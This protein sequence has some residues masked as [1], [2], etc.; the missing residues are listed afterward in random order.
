MRVPNELTLRDAWMIWKNESGS[1][2]PYQ[3]QHPN[4]RAISNNKDT[5]STYEEACE[6]RTNG[7]GIGIALGTKVDGAYLVGVDLDGC[8]DLDNK[9][10]LWAKEILDRFDTY[11]EVSPSDTGVK[12]FFQ[13]R[14]YDEVLALLDGK[15]R[16]AFSIGEHCEVAIDIGARYYAV[17]GRKLAKYP[18]NAR[19]VSFDEVQWLIEEAG[20]K[21]LERHGTIGTT[22]DHSR[23]AEAFGLLQRWK[24]DGKTYEEAR[25][26]ILKW[27][28]RAG[29]WAREW[30]D[31][32]YK[33]FERQ[34]QRAWEVNNGVRRDWPKEIGEDAF[35][36]LAGEIVRMIEPETEADIA[37]LL[38]SFLVMFGNWVGRTAYVR[39]SSTRHY[40]NEYAAMCG[41]S[42]TGRKGTGGDNIRALFKQID[43]VWE[44]R[45]VSGLSTGEGL[46]ARVA[47]KEGDDHKPLFV[48][49]RLMSVT[50]E[51]TRIL[52]QTK[53]PENTLSAVLR[54][55]FDRGSLD[56][57]TRKD[58]LTAHDAHISIVTHITPDE[59]RKHMSSSEMVNGFGN[60]FLNVMVRQSKSL[61]EGGNEVDFSKIIPKLREAFHFALTAKEI[62]RTKECKRLWAEHYDRLRRE[63]PGVFGAM[64]ARAAPHVLRLSLIYAILDCSTVVK[65][66]HLRAALEVWRYC[67]DSIGY[68]FGGS[69]GDDTADAIVAMLRHGALSP[70]DIH[71]GFAN[72]KTAAEIERALMMLTRLKVVRERVEKRTSGRS[73]TTWELI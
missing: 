28:G 1:K 21:F 45:V 65:T 71:R 61:P 16:K 41:G 46:I 32:G 35:Y 3:S 52:A 69:L 33:E 17:T 34:L 10:A 49:K 67:E 31:K 73:V 58:P 57:V 56:I 64:I 44:K 50:P 55:A 9:N 30:K 47:D 51:F 24:R 13:V 4:K 38:V 2:V 25:D 40:T 14:D 72:N 36:G 53:R 66:D 48:D 18:W 60:R 19:V 27:K 15:M 42:A 68:I 26:D 37:N 12:L 11:S 62:K 6:A 39:V 63:V 59:Y 70:T 22:K 23:S 20:P 5:W 8:R 43:P 29:E 54:E 7:D